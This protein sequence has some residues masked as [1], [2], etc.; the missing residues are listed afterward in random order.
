MP[1]IFELRNRISGSMIVLVPK[2][3]NEIKVLNGVCHICNGQDQLPKLHGEI[4][5]LFEEEY[6]LT[7]FKL[8]NG[9]K[10]LLRK[11]SFDSLKVKKN[12][13][14]FYYHCS[15]LARNAGIRDIHTLMVIGLNK[16]CGYFGVKT[17][18]K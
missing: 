6:F 11:V 9:Q 2:A 1:F 7:A 16:G 3:L 18:E 14:W 12:K 4:I 15:K 17:N 8:T 13:R 10:E 5:K